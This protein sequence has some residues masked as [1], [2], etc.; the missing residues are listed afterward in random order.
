V[1]PS[2]VSATLTCDLGHR[3]SPTGDSSG[4]RQNMM[5]AELRFDLS[6]VK[7]HF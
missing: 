6:V 2:G 4:V 3:D 7:I 5:D 1:L